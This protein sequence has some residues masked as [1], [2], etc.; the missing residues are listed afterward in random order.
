MDGA[1]LPAGDKGGK[2]KD[3]KGKGKGKGKDKG[4]KKGSQ[5]AGKG[6]SG[7]GN[8]GNGRQRLGS[9]GGQKRGR[10]GDGDGQFQTVPP[11]RRRPVNHGSS[12]VVVEEAGQAAPIEIYVGNTT[13]A[14]TESIVEA[15]LV[16]CAKGLEPQTEF[17]V[18]EVVQ[19]A[20]QIENPRTKCWKVVVPFKFKELVEND[21]MYP[22]GWCHRKFFSPRQT[23]Q[24]LAILMFE[25]RDRD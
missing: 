4:G 6:K 12:Q 16:K 13:P 9:Q 22:P 21:Q 11:R 5:G 10:D 18:L 3:S 7:G 1:A 17:K 25:S 2:G 24:G 14:A 8:G 23:A 15:V 20:K 19:L